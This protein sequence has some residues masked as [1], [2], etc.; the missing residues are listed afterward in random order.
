MNAAPPP[1]KIYYVP[2]RVT[3]AAGKRIDQKSQERDTG[4]D[5]GA[6]INS[7]SREKK[8]DSSLQ[9][10]QKKETRLRE[11]R[12]KSEEAIFHPKRLN[13]WDLHKASGKVRCYKAKLW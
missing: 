13:S 5:W 1:G 3:V 4:G 6:A 10:E 9:Q 8:N 11:T 12:N 2:A 7:D